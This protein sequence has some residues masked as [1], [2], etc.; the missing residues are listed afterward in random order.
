MVINDQSREGIANIIASDVYV[1]E[2]VWDLEKAQIIPF[3]TIMRRELLD[4]SFEGVRA[5]TPFHADE[6]GQP[7]V[8]H[9]ESRAV[10]GGGGAG[11]ASGRLKRCIDENWKE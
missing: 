8:D 1:Q 3:R 10:E 2:R 11:C 4:G 7:G 9:L 5:G 6:H